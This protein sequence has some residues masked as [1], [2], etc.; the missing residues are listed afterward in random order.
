MHE[1][2]LVY[3]DSSS[4]ATYIL[5]YLD[6]FRDLIIIT[7]GLETLNR[8]MDYGFRVICTGGTLQR[9]ARA[10]YGEEA[11]HTISN[12]YANYCF[13]SCAAFDDHGNVTDVS[14]EENEIR[15]AMMRQSNHKILLCSSE[16]QGIRK[17]HHCCNIRD[18]EGGCHSKAALAF[19]SDRSTR[20]DDF[21]GIAVHKK[22]VQNI[23]S[24]HSKGFFGMSLFVFL[25]D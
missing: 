7:N 10:F 21:G 5:P 18:L 25:G 2:D 20:K 11:F 16:K 23:K 4:T 13:I 24:R 14:V 3:L 17:F 12:Y 19:L 15:R 6:S 9:S 8:A 22:R 1:Q